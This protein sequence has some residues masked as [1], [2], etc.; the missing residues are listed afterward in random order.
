MHLVELSIKNFRGIK[1][2]NH[3]FGEKQ[4]I[5]LVGQSNRKNNYIRSY[6]FGIITKLGYFIL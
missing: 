1:S 3:I 2:F 5:C 4:L 6:I